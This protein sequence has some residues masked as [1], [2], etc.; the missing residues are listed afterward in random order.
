MFS[1]RAITYTGWHPGP[2]LDG[3]RVR[4]PTWVTIDAGGSAGRV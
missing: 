3:R 2:V 1:V 4:I